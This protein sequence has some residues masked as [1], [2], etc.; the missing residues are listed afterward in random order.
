[1]P[2]EKKTKY[3]KIVDNMKINFSSPSYKN[4][5]QNLVDIL[6]IINHNDYI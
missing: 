1:M 2:E 4:L 6:V 5:A 3:T